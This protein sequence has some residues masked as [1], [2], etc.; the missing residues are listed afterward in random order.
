MTDLTPPNIDAKLLDGA[1]DFI[2]RAT[3]ASGV[4]LAVTISEYVIDTFFG[5]NA[6][7]LSSKDPTKT[8]SFR[9]LC[10][11]KDLH[12]GAATLFRLIRVGQQVRHLPSDLSENL[13]QA[14]HRALLAEPDGRQKAHFARQAV[15]HAWTAQKLSAEIAAKHPQEQPKPG[16]PHKAALLKWLGG[17]QRAAGDGLALP[18][19]SEEF[20]ELSADQQQKLTAEVAALQQMLAD[21]L[22]AMG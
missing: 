18:L 9:A 7:L 14:Q 16:R 6:G 11:R 21:V 20:A 13:S 15:K 8:A 22:A 3:H 5:G 10:E 4:Q 12:M 1:V 2:N 17:L 19:V